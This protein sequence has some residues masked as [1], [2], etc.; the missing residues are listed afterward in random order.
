MIPTSEPSQ[1]TT[2]RSKRLPHQYTTIVVYVIQPIQSYLHLQ[3]SSTMNTVYISRNSSPQYRYLK[4]DTPK[5]IG[6][7]DQALAT[8]G[9]LDTVTTWI[10]IN[11]EDANQDGLPTLGPS[12]KKLQSPT[13]MSSKIHTRLEY[14]TTYSQVQW[15]VTLLLVLETQLLESIHLQMQDALVS[16]I[17][18]KLY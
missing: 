17:L 12:R 15:R 2:Y 3:P 11:P 13:T 1:P 10:F 9:I 16:F 7:R 14:F 6:L 8:M 5:I 18:A 4:K